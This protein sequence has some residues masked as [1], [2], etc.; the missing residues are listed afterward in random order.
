M[1]T[2]DGSMGEGGG[3]ILRSALALSL[4][5]GTAFR[6]TKVRAGR[7]R[8]GLLRQHLTALRAA[9]EVCAAE[10]SGAVLGSGEVTFRPGGLRGGAH[11]V[12]IGSAGSTTLV[13]QTVLLPLLRAPEP[14]VFTVE[15]GTHN[16]HA[17]CFEFLAGVY[18]PALAE[19]GAEASVTLLRPGFYPAG[20]GVLEARV[21][22][23][24]LGAWSRVARGAVTAVKATAMVAAVPGAVAHRELSTVREILGPSVSL[25]PQWLD[26]R[27]GP[28]NAVVVECQC[29]GAREVFAAYGEKGVSAERVAEGVARQAAAWMA[30]DVPVG[31]HL[32]DQ[33]LLPMVLGGGGRFVTV[34]PTEH[35]RTHAEVIA[36]FV[37][38]RVRFEAIDGRRWSVEVAGL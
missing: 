8:P 10:V 17:P 19:M 14:S 25:H 11:R 22:P 3:Q 18:L 32:A 27:Y 26:A 6:L 38:A 16:P 34:E 9:G 20:G 37:G 2:L 15:G 31:E 4:V 13:L 29:T 36:R 23:S 30:A 24:T 1:L 5:T 7:T 35:S 28:G 33:M 21:T 12:A